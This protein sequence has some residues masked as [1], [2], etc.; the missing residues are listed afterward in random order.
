[1]TKHSFEPIGAILIKNTK[2]TDTRPIIVM[3]S[4]QESKMDTAW[5]HFCDKIPK[6]NNIGK[7]D[8]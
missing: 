1:M 4:Y 3:T 7:K 5:F 8:F 6:Q 2:S